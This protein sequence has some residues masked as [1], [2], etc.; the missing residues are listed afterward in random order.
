MLR[1]SAVMNRFVQKSG[2][3]DN[4]IALALGLQKWIDLSAE[5]FYTSR[6][7][8]IASLHAMQERLDMRVASACIPEP[9]LTNLTYLHSV[10]PLNETEKHLL[11]F[12][13]AYEEESVI[14]DVF[15]I[16]GNMNRAA[17]ECLIARVL[18]ISRSRIRKSL[19]GD[20]ALLHSSV[21]KNTGSSSNYKIEF[22]KSSLAEALNSE[23]CTVEALIRTVANPAQPPSLKSQDYPHLSDTLD[24]LRT[25]LKQALK[26]KQTGVNIYIHGAPG[27]GKSELCRT[28]AE[29]LKAHLFEVSFQD[30]DGD[31]INGIKRLDSLRMAQ[32]LLSKQRSLLVFDE[33]E[34]VFRGESIFKRSVASE[35][36]AWMNRMFETNPVPT[37][38]VS[39]SLCGLDPAFV[40]RFS[41]VLELNAPP[42]KQRI[43]TYEKI[44]GA[45]ARPDFL[46]TLARSEALTPAVVAQT[47]RV[48]SVICSQKKIPQS[49]PRFEKT[50]KHLVV[51]TLKAQGHSTLELDSTLPPVPKVYDPKLL[52]C[53]V[54]LLPIAESLKN[55]RSCRM[56]FYGPPGTGKTTFGYWLAEQLDVPLHAKKAS[57]I[58]SPFI[59]VAEKNIAR[60][61][62]EAKEEQAILLMDEVDTFLQDRRHAQ[63]SWE[64]SEVNEMLTQMER[65]EGIFIASTNL[66][67]GLDQA[68]LR[69]FDL[70]LKFDYL[71]PNQVVQLC[72]KYLQQLG[73]GTMNT[74]VIQTLERQSALTPGDFANVARQHKFRQFP[75]AEA[76]ADALIDEV[77]LKNES[78]TRK[79]GF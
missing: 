3:K 67:E 78:H 6:K 74:D 56:C 47:K 2:F 24:Y 69:R 16:L 53:D 52:N 20:A 72:N 62:S 51:Q 38:W 79:M 37:F 10:L 76:F 48:A 57:D 68:S 36:K 28:L 63:R 8:L 58:L 66:M 15:R 70:K 25:F 41:F 21:L 5:E 71:A 45:S 26:Q 34:D 55:N 18:K 7:K 29:E 31:S 43:H 60:A 39:N 30:N 54:P 42:R 9:I 73:L 44:F 14:R 1:P 49:D 12:F 59:G 17:F 4:D 22:S 50:F 33:A 77:Q 40:R 19:S 61:F 75:N 27:T 32:V 11:A 65:F 35:R 23:E 46:E 64:V 13:V